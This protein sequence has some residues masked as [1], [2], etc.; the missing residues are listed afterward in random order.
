MKLSEFNC[1]IVLKFINDIMS[2]L[3]EISLVGK[4]KINVWTISKWLCLIFSKY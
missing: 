2:S 1:S 4:L 3:P